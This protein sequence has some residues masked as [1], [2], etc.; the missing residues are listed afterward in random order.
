L[1]RFAEALAQVCPNSKLRD[2]QLFGFEVLSMV[3]DIMDKFQ[4]LPWDTGDILSDYVVQS[5]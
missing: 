4:L 5:I 1:W 2:S 3:I